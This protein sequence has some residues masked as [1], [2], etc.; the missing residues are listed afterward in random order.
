[1]QVEGR[2]D[3]TACPIDGIRLECGGVAR[4]RQEVTEGHQPLTGDLGALKV[5]R[6]RGSRERNGGGNGECQDH[7][8]ARTCGLWSPW[9]SRLLANAGGLALVGE[10]DFQPLLQLQPSA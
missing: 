10:A 3:W 4:R 1:M 7:P 2:M 9:E 5:P 8:G 6:R